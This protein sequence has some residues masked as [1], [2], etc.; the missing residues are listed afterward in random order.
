[1]NGLDLIIK[2][3]AED[4]AQIFVDGTIGERP[5]RFLLDTGAAKTSVI[6]DDYTATFES[7][8]QNTSSGVFAPTTEAVIVVPT[9]EIGPISRSNFSVVRVEQRPSEISNLIGMDLLKDTC[10]HFL[11]DAERVDIGT[12]DTNYPFQELFLGKK[13]HP[14]VDVSFDV[15]TA[16]TVWDTGAS[17]TVVNMAFIRQHPALFKEVG[18]SA[19]TDATGATMD[20]PMFIMS[21]PRIGGHTFPPHKVAGVDLSPMNANLD[22]PMDMILGYSTLGKANWLFDFPGKRWVITKF[23]AQ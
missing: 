12:P 20:T 14:Y 9:L 5:Y 13:A 18:Q 1:M 8:E 23:L 4:E 19:G 17:I 10:C 15:V 3:E 22:N 21:G 7:V 11:F 16:R 6:L 2:H